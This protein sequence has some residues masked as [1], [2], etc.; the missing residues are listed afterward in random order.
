[1]Q[2]GLKGEK[3][4]YFTEEGAQKAKWTPAKGA[5]DYL[6]W[7][8]VVLQRKIFT[9]EIHQVNLGKLLARKCH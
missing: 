7:Y 6:T 1:M 8:K 9:V 2:I 3:L 4:Q 5:G